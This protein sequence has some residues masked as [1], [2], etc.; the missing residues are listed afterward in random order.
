AVAHADD[1]LTA[2]IMLGIS[3]RA[4]IQHSIRRPT[5]PS[6]PIGPERRRGWP[7]DDPLRD[8]GRDTV[9]I[10]RTCVDQGSWRSPGQGETA[11]HIAIKRRITNSHLTLVAGSQHNT[12]ELVR[13][14]HQ[15]H[16][17]YASLQVFL[18]GVKGQSGEIRRQDLPE[19]FV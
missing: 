9:A 17:A 2:A 11:C 10:P 12:A 16:P 18:S 5:I 7:R 4:G 14:R 13:E 8:D 3:L 6:T 19:M 1:F 15:Q